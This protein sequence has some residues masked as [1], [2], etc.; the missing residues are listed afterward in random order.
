VIAIAYNTVRT[1]AVRAAILG[2]LVN[3]IITHPPVATALI[4]QR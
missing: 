1:P 2:G 4:T 3:G